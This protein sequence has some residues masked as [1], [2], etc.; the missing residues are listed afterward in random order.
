MGREFPSGTDI[1]KCWSAG[2]EG[3]VEGGVVKES[4][5]S[6]GG[7]CGRM[8]D[9]SAE[10]GA[11]GAGGAGEAGIGAA[12]VRRSAAAAAVVVVA[13]AAVVVQS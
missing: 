8:K 1:R 6:S 12:A 2:R 4:T 3:E 7:D 5:G 11:G 9:S 10:G 13:A